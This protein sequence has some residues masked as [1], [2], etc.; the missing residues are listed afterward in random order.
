MAELVIIII[1]LAMEELEDLE[2]GARRLL[3]AHM[4][5]E[6]EVA[7]TAEAGRE[8]PTPLAAAVAAEVPTISHLYT[9]EPPPIRARDT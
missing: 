1:M 9:L 3:I 2:V 6:E 4:A 7:D 5:A 8:V